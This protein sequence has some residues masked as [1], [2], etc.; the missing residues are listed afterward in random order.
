MHYS[1]SGHQTFPFRYAWLPKGVAAVREDPAVFGSP[2]ALVRLGVGRNMVASIRHW[3]EALDLFETTKGRSRILPLGML[4][5][6]G[7]DIA[8]TSSASV[9]VAPQQEELSQSN[10]DRRPE[11]G[12][13]LFL[14]QRDTSNGFDTAKPSEAAD[15]YLEDPGT[16]WLLHW[17]L[18]CKPAPASTWHL[19]FTR[20][21]ESVFARDELIQW[22]LRCAE[23]SGNRR[24]S[25]ASIRRD[26]DVFIRTY[27]PARDHIRRPLED[28]FDCPLAELGLLEKVDAGRFALRRGRRPSLPIEIVAFAVLEFWQRVASDRQTL[29]LERVLFDPGSPGGA[30]KLSDRN[31][32]EMLERLPDY[33]GIRY[34]ETAG[35]RLLMRESE[36]D[37]FAVLERYYEVNRL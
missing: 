12:N 37:P 15:P 5:F 36:C 22:L 7:R 10:G 8:S 11:D 18:V 34:D 31:L 24:A 32:V 35:M 33:C 9:S 27:L 19:V 2:H 23:D 28:T 25:R 26:L 1:F 3:G 30:F 16:L 13:Q 6:G 29:A 4:L 14:G 17:R 20:F 21:A